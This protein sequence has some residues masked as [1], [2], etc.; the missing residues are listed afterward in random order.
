MSQLHIDDITINYQGQDLSQFGLFPLIALYFLDVLKLPDYFEQI[1]VNKKRNHNRK[2][3][4]KNRDFSDQDMCMGLLV[5]P[6]LG[7]SRLGQITERLS[8]ETGIAKLLGLP[9]FFD[10][11]TG[12]DYLN[13][14][15]KWHVKQ[16]DSI[17]HQLLLRHGSC[18]S[19]PIVI[20]DIDA[21]THTL[22]S[23]KREKAVV[24]FNRKKRGK[25]CYQWNVAFVCQEAVAQRLVAGNTHCRSVL[26][27]LLDDVA[28]KLQTDLMILRL[29][30]G[31]LSGDI[32]NTLWELGLQIIIPCRY[33][34]ILSQGVALYEPNWLKIDEDTRLYDVGKSGVVSTC[35]HP[36]RVVL[37]EKKQHPFQGSK[38][39]RKL[40]RY[41]ICENLA[42]NL[43]AKGVYDFYHSRQTIEQFFKESTGP[44]SAGKMPS[45][46][47]A[48]NEAY[49]Q[50][51]TI[52]ENCMLWFK[53]NFCLKN[54]NMIPWKPY[55]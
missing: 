35:Y 52:A 8:N 29:D 40:F 33:D 6:I 13:Q 7:I 4:P 2:R 5:L 48:A 46:Q 53:K 43:D 34:W 15:T 20:V 3:K 16:L 24:G 30:S 21:Q 50:L 26:L 36:F 41:A 12:H 47:F 31:Y 38:S 54:G 11:S 23:R 55:V 18:T 25:P 1:T 17:N 42:F 32:L 19:Q 10:Q 37:V 27:E 39:K 9:R 44:F 51:V 49:L 22:E 45:Q 14:F 28:Q